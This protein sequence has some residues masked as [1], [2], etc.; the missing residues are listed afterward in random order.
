MKV[1]DTTLLSLFVLMSLGCGRLDD[2]SPKPKTPRTRTTPDSS[3]TSASTTGN[4]CE[5]VDTEEGA[6][7][8]CGGDTVTVYDGEA[9]EPGAAGE[10][11]IAGPQG[12]VGESG[13]TGESGQDGVS[14]TPE[15]QLLYYGSVCNSLS[16]LGLQAGL[17]FIAYQAEV[18][19]LNTEYTTI[20]TSNAGA[21][22]CKVKLNADGLFGV[23]YAP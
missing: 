17:R 11:G 12:E 15:S 2:L 9:G 7:I 23:Q 3:T 18:F 21:K 1:L 14:P 16:I 5:V 20:W 6:D 4:S 22:Y 19:V 13:Q 8:T 10:P